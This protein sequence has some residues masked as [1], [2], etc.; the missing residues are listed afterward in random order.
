MQSPQSFALKF[1]SLTKSSSKFACW[2]VEPG[3]NTNDLV[4]FLFVMLIWDLIIVSHH[5][6]ANEVYVLEL[7][8]VMSTSIMNNIVHLHLPKRTLIQ[9]G[10][11]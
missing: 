3:S 10:R 7:I 1:S 8:P 2:L 5:F 4:P 6:S 9:R 11:L